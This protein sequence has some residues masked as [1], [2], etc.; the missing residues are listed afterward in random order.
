MISP[1]LSRAHNR[2]GHARA[3]HVL[4]AP[5]T[6]SRAEVERRQEHVHIDSPS[7]STSSWPIG[8]TPTSREYL[9]QREVN[10][11]VRRPDK[12]AQERE[13][14][15][16]R[17]HPCTARPKEQRVNELS[18]SASILCTFYTSP[19]G[20]SIPTP[21]ACRPPLP[22][23]QVIDRRRRDDYIGGRLP[24]NAGHAPWEYGLVDC[25]D[26]RSLECDA[27]DYSETCTHCAEDHLN[28][29]I[30]CARTKRKSYNDDW[31]YWGP[32]G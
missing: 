26:C 10:Q 23:P 25:R 12:R 32:F 31:K 5:P 18:C 3:R 17:Q 21:F 14:D 22:L 8:S 11:G 7:K 15:R 6:Q 24:D 27:N 16:A 19:A 28:H 2:H 29:I 30:I 20:K 9:V 1:G 4:Q 13:A